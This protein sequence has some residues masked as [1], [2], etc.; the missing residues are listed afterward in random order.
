MSQSAVVK[1]AKTSSS[2][3]HSSHSTTA[4]ASQPNALLR[5]NLSDHFNLC[6]GLRALCPASARTRL[7]KAT[8][9][10]WTELRASL[11]HSP[12]GQTHLDAHTRHFVESNIQPLIGEYVRFL[13]I[14]HLCPNNVSPPLLLDL[15]W[16]S[17]MLM[18]RSYAKTCTVLFDDIV[19]HSVLDAA[20]YTEAQLTKRRRLAFAYYAQWFEPSPFAQAV[21]LY[22][23]TG[24]IMP[25]IE[26]KVE[27]D[28]R[29][30][31]A[32]TATSDNSPAAP[33]PS[34]PLTR[35]RLKRRRQDETED[36]NNV[37]TSVQLF[38]KTLTGKTVTVSCSVHDTVAAL[39]ANIYRI[40]SVPPEQQRLIF[41]GKQLDDSRSLHSYNISKESTIH[42]VLKLSGC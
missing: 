13:C 8:T 38:V 9:L 27:P 30:F 28:D 16:H 31:P 7:Q 20:D 22:N 25:R 39:K 37:P 26:A 2:A 35:S 19:G 18:P 5:H 12:G 41:A 40:D 11:Y 24:E 14:R 33:P 32:S 17:H 1:R 21:W 3:I 6:K 29:H 15:V 4:A 36:S 34:P 23:G 10:P 42:M